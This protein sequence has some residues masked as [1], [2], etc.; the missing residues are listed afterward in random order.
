MRE[1]D[2]GG[3]RRRPPTANAPPGPRSPLPAAAA[4]LALLVVSCG[5]PPAPARLPP[6]AVEP[7]EA[8]VAAGEIPSIDVELRPVPAPT[9]PRLW[10][11]VRLAVA[12]AA[13]REG[14]ALA[15][16][17]Q[18]P[19]AGRAPREVSG[20]LGGSGTIRFGRLPEGGWLG[21]AP[22]PVG[23]AGPRRLVVRV[24]A[25]PDSTVLLRR[26]VR[27]SNHRFPSTSLK[28]ARRYSRPPDAVRERIERE[29]ELVAEALSS[30][31]EEWLWRGRF[32]WPRP[33]RVTSPFGQRRVF[34]GETRGRHWGL[35]LAGRVGDPVRAAARG[36]VVLARHLYYSGNTV[37]LDHGHG[38]V[39]GY[40]HLSEIT[41]PTGDTVSSGRVIGEVGA[42]GRVTGPHLHWTL[43]VGGVRL[44]A[45]SLM[46]LDLF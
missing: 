35:D 17:V 21:L 16:R 4:L 36:R 9:P 11:G 29:R 38:V 18:A 13:P 8:A 15:V 24:S 31:A 5:L 30:T 40:A 33:Y 23:E 26:T 14:R 39:T 19:P 46:D 41:V 27:V 6:R 32:T 7:P 22:L 37:L 20:R 34:N 42:T 2:R 10:L 25:T 28:V 45:S 43:Q 12:P 1:A 44:D 3:H